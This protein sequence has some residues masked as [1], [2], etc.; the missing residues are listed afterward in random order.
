MLLKNNV[1]FA[2][3][4]DLIMVHS[5]VFQGRYTPRKILSISNESSPTLRYSTSVSNDLAQC[6]PSCTG[7]LNEPRQ[8][9]CSPVSVE[10]VSSKFERRNIETS[11]LNRMDR[12]E[13]C[14]QLLLPELNQ[15]LRKLKEQLSLDDDE[16][17]NF[18]S[19]KKELLPHGN[20]NVETHD[21]QHLNYEIKNSLDETLQNPLDEFKQMSDGHFDEDGM[22]YDDML[23][24][25]GMCCCLI[26]CM[27]LEKYLFVKVEFIFLVLDEFNKGKQL[28]TKMFIKV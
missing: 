20:L 16:E 1:Y 14:N 18:V 21:L 22:Q 7:E 23:N 27:R 8:N 26:Y 19:P 5:C 12:S 3:P 10:E 9:S 17:D 11:H 2:T 24:N 25:S 13:S 4:G 28:Y 15:A 6:F